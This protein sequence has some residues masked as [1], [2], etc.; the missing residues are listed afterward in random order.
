MKIYTRDETEHGI[1]YVREDDARDAALSAVA[2]RD[3]ALALAADRLRQIDADRVLL[4]VARRAG[5]AGC[6][7]GWRHR[8]DPDG[9]N[10]QAGQHVRYDATV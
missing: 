1:N 7:H 3:A 2:E 8:E 4:E 10:Q 9:G 6:V 5:C